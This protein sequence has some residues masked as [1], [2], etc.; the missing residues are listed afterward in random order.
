[1]PEGVLPPAAFQAPAAKSPELEA[2]HAYLNGLSGAGLD[3]PR[4]RIARGDS[5]AAITIDGI[6]FE[7]R[8]EYVP[9]L[10]ETSSGSAFE[11]GAV[12]LAKTDRS[13]WLLK[14]ASRP[15]C[16]DISRMSEGGRRTLAHFFGLLMADD[17]AIL[18]PPRQADVF[19]ASTSYL[20][21]VRWSLEHPRKVRLQSRSAHLG[22]WVRQVIADARSPE[23]SKAQQ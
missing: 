22:D 1:M 2:A 16:M 11:L 15:V 13:G 4:L 20:A 18:P 17:V 9:L 7:G 21:L 14:Q 5:F 3:K 12:T 8:V 19:R 23:F 6:R 10:V